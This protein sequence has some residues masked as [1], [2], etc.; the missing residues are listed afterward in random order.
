MPC[1]CRSLCRPTSNPLTSR[2]ICSSSCWT[3]VRRDPRPSS[4]D[5]CRKDVRSDSFA[6]PPASKSSCRRS[7]RTCSVPHLTSQISC[8][9]RAMPNA[10]LIPDPLL[11]SLVFSLNFYFS[12]TQWAKGCPYE[13]LQRFALGLEREFPAVQAALT[14]PWSTGQVEGQI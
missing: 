4:T 7:S 8:A 9:M 3:P 10:I 2:C 13:E 11:S 12:C 1:T 6:P 14:E 5:W